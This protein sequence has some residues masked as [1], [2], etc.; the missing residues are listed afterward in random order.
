MA[1]LD[2]WRPRP[3]LPEVL[4]GE[5]R[6]FGSGLFVDLV[7][8]TCWF[9]NAR[10]CISQRDWERVQRMVVGRAGARCEVCGAGRDAQAQ[11]WLEVHECWAYNDADRVQSLRR[12]IC[13]CTRCHQATHFGL[14]QVRGTAAAARAHLLTVTG[15]TQPQA[16]QH[17]T[18]AFQVWPQR[19]QHA[20]ALDLTLLTAAGI[21]LTPPQTHTRAEASAAGPC[22]RSSCRELDERRP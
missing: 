2:P 15:M 4:P 1:A 16:E 8:Q 9:T 17:I 21:D 11:R 18:T 10:S 3:P 12:L 22:R 13:L 20:W 7:P 5:D 14:A 19:S 6:S